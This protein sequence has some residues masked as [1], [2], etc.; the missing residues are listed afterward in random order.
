MSN[1]VE[2]LISDVMMYF[3]W[4]VGILGFLHWVKR[5]ETRGF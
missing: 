5:K 3:Y 4:T 1:I 2:F